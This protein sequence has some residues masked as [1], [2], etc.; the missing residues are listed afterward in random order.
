VTPKRYFSTD[1]SPFAFTCLDDRAGVKHARG[2]Y[3]MADDEEVVNRLPA[4]AFA[5]VTELAEEV[6]GA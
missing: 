4:E 5:A 1:G 6:S 3:V 2:C